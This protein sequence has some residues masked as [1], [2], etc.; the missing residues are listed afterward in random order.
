MDKL[1]KP[2]AIALYERM[3]DFTALRHKV[4]ANN[5]ANVNTPG[6]QRS[7]VEFADEL[8]RVL[9][10]KGIAGVEDLKL[11]LTQPNE[12]A[13]RNDGNN[14]SVEKE[15]TSLAENAIMYQVY[16]QLLARKFRQIDQILKDA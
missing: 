13:F 6:F 2:E 7:D 8:S 3:L 15:M 16:A 5:I 9:Q 4:L 14:V 10:D 1:I 11:R 12:T